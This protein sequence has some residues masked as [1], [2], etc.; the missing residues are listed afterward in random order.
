MSSTAAEKIKVLPLR[1]R[2]SNNKLLLL[3]FLPG[4]IHLLIFKYAPM[5][6]LIIIFQD[7]NPFRGF[8]KSDWVGLK[9][10]IDIFELRQ[11]FKLMWN[12][13]MLGVYRLVFGFPAPIILAL[14]INEI[15]QTT[16]KRVFQ[17]ISYIPYFISNVVVVSIAAIV[18]SPR[19]G[20]VNKILVAVFNIEP[21]YFLIQPGLFRPIYTLSGIWKTAGWS[22]IIYLAALSAINPELYEAAYVDGAR[23]LRQVWHVTLPGITPTI[24]VLL[25]ISIGGIFGAGFELAFLYQNSF[26]LNHSEILPTYIYKIGLAGTL[27]L[28]KYSFAAALGVFQSLVNIIL[29]VGANAISRK[30]NATS[31]W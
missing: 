19:S 10:F 12:T 14:I 1:K 28:P 8:V 6:G 26:N 31:L 3:I 21:I 25:I 4:L 5:F 24:V 27:G 15:R 18:L 23:R 9:H 29:L 11:S 30:V 7:Y 20:I 17:T 2:I 22:A 13:L 16:F